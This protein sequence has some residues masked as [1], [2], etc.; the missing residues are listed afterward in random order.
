MRTSANRLH[1]LR[2]YEQVLSFGFETAP[3]SAPYTPPL[4]TEAAES[5]L[6]HFIPPVVQKRML[7]GQDSIWLSEFRKVCILFVALPG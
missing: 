3:A 2:L 4:V 7:A 5:A 1:S 6:Q